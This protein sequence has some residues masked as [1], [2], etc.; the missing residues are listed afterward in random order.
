M[1]VFPK[2]SQ[3]VQDYM[4]IS[5]LRMLL[6]QALQPTLTKNIVSFF[7][8]CH[9]SFDSNTGDEKAGHSHGFSC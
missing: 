7:Q 3:S 6:S 4:R 8:P 5:Y 1:P 2:M 9:G